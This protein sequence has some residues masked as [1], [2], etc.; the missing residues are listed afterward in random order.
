MNG[1]RIEP[2]PG[3]HFGGIVDR[4]KRPRYSLADLGVYTIMFA[5]AVGAL[6]WHHDSRLAA[7]SLQ[8]DQVTAAAFRSPLPTAEVIAKRPIP[9]SD[10]EAY[11]REYDFSQNWFTRNIPLW[12]TVLEPFQGRPG[13][14]YLEV[15]LYEGR[16][17][18]L[19]CWKTS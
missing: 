12:G 15:G 10:K 3:V 13:V 2:A 11:R 9:K 19:G 18:A 1:M 16:S 5:A 7:I 8:R 4:L 6:R 14:S 17:C